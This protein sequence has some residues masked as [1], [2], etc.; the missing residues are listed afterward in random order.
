MTKITLQELYRARDQAPDGAL[1]D[2]LFACEKLF[3]ATRNQPVRVLQLGTESPLSTELLSA[4][5]EN[6]ALLAV[7]DNEANKAQPDADPRI[8]RIAGEPIAQQLQRGGWQFDIV[9][10]NLSR[11]DGAMAGAI[12]TYW[13]YIVEGGMYVAAGLV[14][15]R[16]DLPAGVDS[17]DGAL[18][19]PSLPAAMLFVGPVAV[20]HKR[21]AQ[22]GNGRSSATADGGQDTSV[23]ATLFESE[24]EIRRL[25]QLLEEREAYIADMYRST[26][27]RVT[28]PMRAVSSTLI[29]TRRAGALFAS[30][31]RRHGG[32][33]GMLKKGYALYRREGLAGIRRG[34]RVVQI[35]VKNDRTD[36]AEWLRRYDIVTDESRAATRARIEG[37][38]RRPLIS[39][40]MPVYNTSVEFLDQA[41]WSVRNQV[42]ANWELC[43]ADDAS[44]RPE[45]RRV[46]ERHS[47]AD[48]RIRVVY[49]EQNGHISASSNSALALVKGEF[50][51]L[52]DHD[53]LLAAQA[54]FRVVEAINQHPDAG[55]IYSDE[56]KVD[57]ANVRYDPY[58]KS[59][60]NYELLLAQNSL[61]HLGVYR[62]ELVRRVG[63]F[64]VGFEGAQDYD[65]A[66]RVIEQ[67]D[68][69]RV[70]HLP[71]VLYHWR[72]I[73]GST[74]LAASEKNYAAEAGRR[75]VQEHLTRTGVQAEVMPA[76]GLPAVNRV[77]FACP[78][79]QPLVS[80]LIPTRDRAD[81]LGMCL[82]SLIERTTYQNYEV[83]IIDNGS[84]E[85]ATQRLFERLP[86]DRFRIIRDDSPFNFSALNNHAARIAR[87]TL[88]CLMNNDIEILTPDWLEEMVSFA[89]RL[90]IGCVGAR[91]WYP[92]GRLQHGGCVIGIGGVAGHAHKYLQHGREGYFGRAML[93]QAFSAVTAACLLI[94]REIYDELGGLDEQLVVAFNDVDFC[95]RVREAGYRN[96]WTPYAEMIHH[97]SA[98]RGDENT[99]AKQERFAREVAY[100]KARWGDMLLE[101]P[102][103]SPNLTMVHEDF[104]YAWPPRVS[105]I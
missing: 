89:A 64:R 25:K 29:R 45:V 39:V 85:E 43:I 21:A 2:H 95:L 5:F 97:E 99:P 98:S 18:S 103:Y 36:Y 16:G 105:T 81:L 68:P 50:I 14:Q 80:I 79:P 20:L 49:R 91:L 23:Q 52:L 101:D 33:H 83:I 38:A 84:V 1:P 7:L 102:A 10:D 24:R 56:D 61:S 73:P 87:G 28:R 3:E 30:T 42:Y 90:D 22:V 69:T 8:V 13:P 51:A 12:D 67:L 26:S 88:L 19:A 59:E 96:V 34:L 92:D 27:W 41:I 53:D 57:A 62:T 37:F 6:A 77:R 44:T 11:D 15:S 94:R 71:Y 76:P 66:L 78:S 54:L 72:A 100:V 104:S 31:L 75:A 40:L 35:S 60:L 70:L 9:I 48:T 58:F 86:K 46:L 17:S 65:L 4:Y 93:H 32:P 74:A 82:D 55:V 47:T 63:G